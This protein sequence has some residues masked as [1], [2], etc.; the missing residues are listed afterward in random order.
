MMSSRSYFP[1]Y[2]SGYVCLCFLFLLFSFCMCPNSLLMQL[3]SLDVAGSTAPG[4]PNPMDNPQTH[5]TRMRHSLFPNISCT[6]SLERNMIGL[7]WVS[8][9]LHC[10]DM[11]GVS[12]LDVVDG[13]PS[14]V[15]GPLGILWALWRPIPQCKEESRVEETKKKRQM[16]STPH[17]LWYGNVPL[18]CSLSVPWLILTFVKDHFLGLSEP[19]HLN[20]NIYLLLKVWGTNI[21]LCFLL[22]RDCFLSP[23]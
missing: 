14:P 19:F 2:L 20:I 1:L 11:A 13:V 23:Q 22:F 17:T 7:A 12:W 15:A 6:R 16:S 10:A 21:S 5:G 8:A 4:S 9:Q 18:P 3:C